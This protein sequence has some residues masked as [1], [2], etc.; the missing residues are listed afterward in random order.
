[1]KMKNK[2]SV[3]DR[4]VDRHF[5]GQYVVPPTGN[6]KFTDQATKKAIQD[7]KKNNSSK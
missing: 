2:T 5:D 7:W 6:T 3:I 1:M 4:I